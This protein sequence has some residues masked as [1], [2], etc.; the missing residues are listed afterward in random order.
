MGADEL[1]VTRVVM[2]AKLRNFGLFRILALEKRSM[3][4]RQDLSGSGFI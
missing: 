2:D 1:P 3:A 4:T